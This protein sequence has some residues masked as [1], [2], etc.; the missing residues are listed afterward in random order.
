[1]SKSNMDEID[2]TKYNNGVV[3]N[4]SLH[5]YKDYL[6]GFYIKLCNDMAFNI[7]SNIEELKSV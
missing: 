6:E 4:T 7:K 2:Y 1:M 3:L 5:T